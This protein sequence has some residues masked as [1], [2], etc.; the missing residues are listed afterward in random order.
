[1]I[2]QLFDFIQCSPTASHTAA[3]VR[4]MLAGQRENEGTL[5]AIRDESVFHIG[6]SGEY[7]GKY[8]LQRLLECAKK[9]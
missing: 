3:T 6:H 1:M 4:A 9:Q 8:L 2:H 7:A 5:R